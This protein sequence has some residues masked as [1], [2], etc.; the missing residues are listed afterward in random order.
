MAGTIRSNCDEGTD[1][2]METQFRSFAAA[3]VE[4]ILEELALSDFAG[5]DDQ[6][7]LSL[8]LSGYRTGI[9]SEDTG[10]RDFY[11]SELQVRVDTALVGADVETLQRF[12]ATVSQLGMDELAADI[13]ALLE[14]LER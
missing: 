10:L 9:F 14:V 13:L 7:F 4:N 8:M 12:L 2:G 1:S 3:T 5:I 6:T 11:E